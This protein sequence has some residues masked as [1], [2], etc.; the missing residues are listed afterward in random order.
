MSGTIIVKAKNT[1]GTQTCEAEL[2][3]NKKGNHNMCVVE[4]G[5]YVSLI[6]TEK[7]YAAY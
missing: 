3:V 7:L 1:S 2:T 5:G 4:P 6:E